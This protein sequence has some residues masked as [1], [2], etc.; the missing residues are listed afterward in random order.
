ML[1]A[2]RVVLSVTLRGVSVQGI[3]MVAFVD[4]PPGTNSMAYFGVCDVCVRA[5]TRRTVTHTCLLQYHALRGWCS[6]V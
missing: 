5:L 6:I 3:H 1:R 2:G 4:M